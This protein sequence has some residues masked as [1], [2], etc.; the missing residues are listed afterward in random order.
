MPA[1]AIAAPDGGL[2]LVDWIRARRG[3]RLYPLAFL[4][5]A[6]RFA[7]RPGW[8]RSWR[9]TASTSHPGTLSSGG[10]PAQS[11]PGR[12]SWPAGWSWPAGKGWP[13]RSRTWPPTASS[14][15]VPRPALSR[16]RRPR[17]PGGREPGGQFPAVPTPAAGTPAPPPRTTVS[18][19]GV[20]GTGL[21]V[22]AVRA[23]ETARPD[24]L[25]AD[26]LAAVFA[27]AGGLEPGDGP[28]GRRGVALRAW[29]VARTLFLDD[30]LAGATQQGCRQVVLLGS[31]FDARA[32]RLPWPMATRCF[33]VDTPEVLG[34][35]DEVLAAEHAVPGC[36]RVVVPCDLRDDW[37][38]ALRAPAW[39]R[40]GRPPGSPRACSS[41]W[42]RPTWTG[43]WTR[44]PGSRPPAA[45]WG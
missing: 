17:H 2:V 34:P 15:C 39:T 4:L 40:P 30:L 10:W 1:N 43:C 38:A 8:T 13:K 12:S 36:E 41:T 21:A 28:G 23:G 16:P 18:L 42:P 32:F 14:R 35:K 33:E 3:P 25:F 9:A 29:V 22:A 24:R 19:E 7:G 11:G 45:G 44:S 5:W 6:A 20:G 31:G 26:P 27:A 37:P